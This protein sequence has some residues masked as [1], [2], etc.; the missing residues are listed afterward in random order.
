MCFL[1]E[2]KVQEWKVTKQLRK[3]LHPLEVCILSIE[4]NNKRNPVCPCTIEFL[5]PWCQNIAI[6]GTVGTEKNLFYFTQNPLKEDLRILFGIFFQTIF[7]S[8]YYSIILFVI[9][10]RWNLF[11]YVCKSGLY[12]FIIPIPFHTLLL[13]LL[14]RTINFLILYQHLFF[15]TLFLPL[16]KKFSLFFIHLSRLLNL[17]LI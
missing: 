4:N 13:L 17:K 10:M 15:H 14:S 6:Y 7:F 12:L 11:L 9:S 1:K 3:K 5:S 2:K 16:P 8:Q